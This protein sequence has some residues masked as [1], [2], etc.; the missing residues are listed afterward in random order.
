MRVWLPPI[1][2]HVEGHP[3]AWVSGSFLAACVVMGSVFYTAPRHT[4]AP[5]GG[6]TFHGHFASSVIGAVLVA[7]FAFGLAVVLVRRRHRG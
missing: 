5:S 7:L 3:K 1:I 2:R 6:N 4:D